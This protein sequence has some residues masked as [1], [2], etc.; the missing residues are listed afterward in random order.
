Y[1]SWTEQPVKGRRAGGGQRLGE[2]EVWA[3]EA[4]NTPELLREFLTYKSDDVVTR[5]DV[6]K[7]VDKDWLPSHLPESFRVTAFLCGGRG[8]KLDPSP[9]AAK[10]PAA[11]SYKAHTAP[12]DIKRLRLSVATAE[13][14]R[15]WGPHE[16]RAVQWRQTNKTAVWICAC[17][18]TEGLHG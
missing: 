17:P 6:W 3:L 11:L 9:T 10:E 14:I 16:V 18:G 2:M 15:H 12:K 1:A 7:Q 8:L 4:H 5:Q 13:D